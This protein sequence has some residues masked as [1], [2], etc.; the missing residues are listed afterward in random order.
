MSWRLNVLRLS[1]IPKVSHVPTDTIV[2]EYTK[3]PDAFT[4]KDEWPKKCNYLCY[5]C[6]NPITSVPLFLPIASTPQ[7]ISRKDKLLMC[8]PSCLFTHI[9]TFA[10]SHSERD[11]QMR[12]ARELICRI[13]GIPVVRQ[14]CEMTEPRSVLLEYGGTCDRRT[15]RESIYL[16]NKDYFDIVS[17]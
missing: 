11:N 14:V 3:I 2:E 6:T 17:P 7:C 13:S 8:S 12:L 10:L 16:K 4:T 1:D 9:A 15:Y 5:T